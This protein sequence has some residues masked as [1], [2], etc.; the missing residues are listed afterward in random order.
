MQ[1]CH[2]AA[3]EAVIKLELGWFASLWRRP[4]RLDS[5]PFRWKTQGGLCE[6][7]ISP[8][9][10]LH[11]IGQREWLCRGLERQVCTVCSCSFYAWMT[12]VTCGN[13]P[14]QAHLL[15]G[16]TMKWKWCNLEGKAT[17]T[18]C[19]SNSR[20]QLVMT[21]AQKQHRHL[22]IRAH[23]HEQIPRYT[24]TPTH[25]H[26]KGSTRQ[27]DSEIMWMDPAGQTKTKQ[28][29]PGLCYFESQSIETTL[30]HSMEKKIS[31]HCLPVHML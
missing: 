7:I 3:S 19:E 14:L 9:H 21:T 23:T 13:E 31:L 15:T 28:Q 24:Q 20:E 27:N 29:R 17:G 8:G 1:Q 22:F 10:R 4:R 11:Y 6:L 26:T 12:K 2:L 16:I 25:T 5:F 30:S 18:T